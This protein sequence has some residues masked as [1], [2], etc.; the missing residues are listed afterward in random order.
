MRELHVF[1]KMAN[2]WMVKFILIMY[3]IEARE[4]QITVV[5]AYDVAFQKL[6]LNRQLFADKIPIF[7]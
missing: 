6:P 1:K 5:W 3:W 7:H 2:E 4:I